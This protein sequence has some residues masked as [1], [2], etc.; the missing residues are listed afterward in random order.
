[1]SFFEDFKNVVRQGF[2][3]LAN[4]AVLATEKF[5]EAVRAYYFQLKK[6]SVRLF[7][8]AVIPLLVVVPCLLFHAPWQWLYGTYIAWLVLLLAAELLLLTPI[9]LVWKH[10][11]AL[12]I[13]GPDLQE[14]LGFIKTVV[15]TGLSLAIFATLFPIWR[16]PGAFPLLLLVLACWLALPACSFNQFCKKIYP[17]VRGI[18]LLFLAGLLVMQM[19]FPRHLD[20]LEWVMA[21]KFG[22]TLTSSVKQQDITSQWKT[23]QWFNN[24]GEPQVWFSGSP[25]TS[26][27]L[28]AAPG[29]DPTSGKELSPVA[30]EKTRSKIV[31]VFTEQDRL[32][33][34]A[35]AKRQAV[36]ANQAELER[37]TREA[38]KQQA[39]ALAVIRQAEEARQVAEEKQR[40]DAKEREEYLA[41]Y[42]VP[43]QLKN[44]LESQDVA[45]LVVNEMLQ[46]NSPVG[47]GL[48][49]A[50]K[51]RS[52]N[53]SGSLFTP[54]FISDGLFE[55][56]FA[57][58][59]G[60]LD[61]LTLTNNADILLLARESVEYPKNEAM[62]ELIT[63]RLKLELSALSAANHRQPNTQTLLSIGAGFKE[64]DA[65]TLAEERLLKQISGKELDTFFNVIL[66]KPH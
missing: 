43:E 22:G 2:Q 64:A 34:E 19:A 17:F 20:Q 40:R 12:P 4:L 23:L 37:H 13:L 58:S 3:L 59:Q 18:Q 31:A 24:V 1:M 30:D 9:A 39:E 38:Q 35:N 10:I 28:W 25:A 42:L 50:L 63:A 16:S 15:F 61:G 56:A 52:A 8:A 66:S 32:E 62:P 45:V 53:A 33:Q 36:L 6:W 11:K 46:P 48:V 21:R 54:A 27:R 41:R 14:W 65:R 55:K 47:Q 57:G 7:L 5:A 60:V 29:F 49:V 44:S 26:F 51:A